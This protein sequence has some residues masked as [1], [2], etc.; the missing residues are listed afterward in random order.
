MGAVFSLPFQGPGMI[1]GQ[2]GSVPSRPALLFSA[3][4]FH[5]MSA[6]YD[7]LIAQYR[8]KSPSRESFVNVV[9]YVLGFYLL[10]FPFIKPLVVPM[11][12]FT[13]AYFGFVFSSLAVWDLAKL[14][15]HKLQK[16]SFTLSSYSQAVLEL[17]D[18]QNKSYFVSWRRSIRNTLAF[19]RA[20]ALWDTLFFSLSVASPKGLLSSV[21]KKIGS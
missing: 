15:H 1:P 6:K 13:L 21:E 18:I 16:V 10:I 17:L 7:E 2:R 20:R 4:Y 8:V 19:S 5:Y 12:V 11:A 14:V 3:S 9:A